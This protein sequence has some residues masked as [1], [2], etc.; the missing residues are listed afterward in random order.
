MFPTLGTIIN[1]GHRPEPCGKARC[2]GVDHAL[3][4]GLKNRIC[5]FGNIDK[6]V[7]QQVFHPH[8]QVG[9]AF[10]HILVALGQTLG[11]GFLVHRCCLSTWLFFFLGPDSTLVQP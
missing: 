10:H 9:H 6:T 5:T 8:F 7:A 1:V 3:G 4:H 11:L 2:L